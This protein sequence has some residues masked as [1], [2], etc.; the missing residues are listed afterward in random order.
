MEK[1]VKRAEQ[2]QINR[3]HEMWKYFDKICFATKTYTIMPIIL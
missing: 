3:N 2:I 1:V